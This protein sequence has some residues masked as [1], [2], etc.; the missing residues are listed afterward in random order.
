M[1]LMI[2]QKSVTNGHLAAK[3]QGTRLKHM[4]SG[5]SASIEGAGDE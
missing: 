4:E 1:M 5:A 2:S 3:C